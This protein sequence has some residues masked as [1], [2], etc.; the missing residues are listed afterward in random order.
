MSSRG[1]G[2]DPSL[3]TRESTLCPVQ[4]LRDAC[5]FLLLTGGANADGFGSRDVLHDFENVTDS[6]FADTLN[7]SFAANVLTG[8]GG[9][10]SL[11]R[12]RG[13]DTLLGGHGND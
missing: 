5:R 4:P 8:G 1:G 6:R 7:G 11:F 9:N 12:S 10:D 13:G 2:V 3:A